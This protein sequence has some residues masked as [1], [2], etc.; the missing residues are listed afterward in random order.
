MIRIDRR[1][2]ILTFGLLCFSLLFGG[3]LPFRIFYAML[4]ML[5]ISYL[6]IRIVRS[7]FDMEIICSETVLSAGSSS[8]VLTKIKFDMP[9][10]VPYIEIRSDAFTAARSH[11]SGFVRD[12]TWDENIWIEDDIQFC[13]RGIHSLDNINIKVS[14]LFHITCF[15]KNMNTGIKIKVYPLI[16]KIKPLTLGGID[17]YQETADLKSRSEDQHTIRDVRKYREGDSLKKVHWKLSAKQDDLYVKNLDTISGEEIVLFVDM[18]KKNYTFDDTG[19]IEESIVDFSS[20]IVNQMIRKNLSIKVFLNTS[21]G[22]YF[23]L[24]DKPGYNKLMDYL[25]SQKSDGTLELFQYIYENSYRLHKMNKIAIVV[26]ELDDNL[27]EALIRM[28]SSGYLIS[29][30]Y[31]IDNQAQKNYSSMLRDSQIECCYFNDYIEP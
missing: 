19:I 27:A 14:D 4:F 16:Y 15:E 9:L 20:S 11:Y 10:P 6:Y 28:S 22:R 7:V 17:I 23:E 26:S 24:E 2:I 12:T 18:N 3:S 29:V 30:F 25:L 1:F 13:Q 31:C 21:P 8:R 5:I